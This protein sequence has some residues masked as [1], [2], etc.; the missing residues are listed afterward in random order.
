MDKVYQVFVSST[1]SDLQEERKQV[2]DT[3]AKAGF[4]PAGM[5]LFPATDQQQ[6]EFIKRVIDRCDYYVVIVAGRYGSLDGDK[7]FTEKEYEYAVEKKIP[8]L[9]FIHKE[10]GK[11]E[12]DK[13]DREPK[14]TKRL[15]AFRSRLKTSRMVA[16]WTNVHELRTEILTA[17]T[18]AVNLAPGVGWV[19]G[20]QAIDPKILQELERVRIENIRLTERLRSLEGEEITFPSDLL[21]PTDTVGISINIE[22]LGAAKDTYGQRDVLKVEEITVSPQI[23]ALFEDLFGSLLKEPPEHSLQTT[24]GNILLQQAGRR[25]DD[26]RAEVSEQTVIDLRFHLEALG[27]IRAAVREQ[28]L[29]SSG[30]GHK[31]IAWTI[32]D[33]G[34]RFVAANRAIRKQ[35]RRAD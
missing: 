7:S 18:N 17:V 9:A 15:D 4:I 22:H 33:K 27:L 11:I 31:Y 23:G 24:I 3:L 35:A 20:D 1:F 6:L 8:V 26:T 30:Y 10:P 13:A 28:R 34:R 2:S 32:T 25:T 19:R 16:F 5:E 12:V 21:G 29:N 14:Q